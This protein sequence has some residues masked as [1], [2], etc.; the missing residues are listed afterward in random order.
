MTTMG[1][2]SVA[3]T[4]EA[5]KVDWG[6]WKKVDNMEFQVVYATP[7]ILLAPTSYFFKKMLHNPK[8]PFI[9][10]LVTVAVDECHTP[11][12][13]GEVFRPYYSM[14]GRLRQC[15]SN[16][17]FIGFSATLTPVDIKEFIRTLNLIRP[18]VIKESVRRKNLVIWG[19]PITG[20]GWE[21]L[22]QLIPQGISDADEI[23]KTLV[24]VNGRLEANHICQWLRKQL[25][26]C[27][28]SEGE[29]IVRA[30]SSPLCEESRAFTIAGLI[31]GIVRI[32]VCKEALGMGV[33][34]P[35]I[36][37]A[38][39]WKLY[40]NITIGS[41][42]QRL[43][44]AGRGSTERVLGL[45]FLSNSN[46]QLEKQHR[47]KKGSDKDKTDA[48]N[49]EATENES[50]AVSHLP[51]RATMDFDIQA[52]KENW[53]TIVPFLQSIYNKSPRNSKGQEKKACESALAPAVRWTIQTKGCHHVPIMVAFD[54]RTK[55]E[56]CSNP[57]CDP[58]FVRNLVTEGNLDEPPIIQGISLAITLAYR[59]YTEV[60]QEKKSI[61][62]SV[63]GQ[64]SSARLDTLQ[65]NILQWRNTLAPQLIGYPYLHVSMVL[66]DKA[67]QTV[68]SKIRCLGVNEE[69]LKSILSAC[70][71]HFPSSMLTPYIPDLVK[72]ITESLTRS[73]PPAQLVQAFAAA[74]TQRPPTGPPRNPPDQEVRSAYHPIQKSSSASQSVH[75]PIPKPFPCI[76]LAEVS[77]SGH[78]SNSLANIRQHRVSKAFNIFN[79][80]QKNCILETQTT[81]VNVSPHRGIPTVKI[82]LKRM[83]QDDPEWFDRFSGSLK[84]QCFD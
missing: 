59:R 55:F 11:S 40:S 71:H 64:L 5:V 37:R 67:I 52:T 62:K 38:V 41:L 10:N 51:P 49:C 74:T 68:K 34:I 8:S 2:R 83:R 46:L 9:T 26:P 23:P 81:A 56:T 84:R 19:A 30:Y 44:R 63:R 18:V 53:S 78:H 50:E 24:F 47:S 60:P 70:G 35:D 48:N 39:V 14:L 66:S 76:P 20:E 16:A 32:A 28:Q 4:S 58:C 65:A 15:L 69:D 12:D 7:E 80:G 27:L 13:W 31:S 1:I 73:Q 17:T 33:N 82:D 45:I 54:D 3:M 77:H 42:Y 43:G 36:K 57:V 29:T 79:D 22:K 61:R 72:C 21:D 25:P 75:W 6:L